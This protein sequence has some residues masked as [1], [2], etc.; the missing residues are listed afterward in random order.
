MNDLSLHNSRIEWWHHVG[1]LNSGSKSFSYQLTFFRKKLFTKQAFVVHMS[2]S[3]LNQGLYFFS[4]KKTRHACIACIDGPS[5]CMKGC[6]MSPKR[7][8]AVCDDFSF[9]LSLSEGR[10]VYHKKPNYYS[11][12]DVE[13]SGE[14][15]ID[16]DL[17]KVDGVSWI[18]H[19]WPL[20]LP[21]PKIIGWDWFALSLANGTRVMLYRLCLK[22]GRQHFMS[23]GSVIT[24]SKVKYLLDEEFSI[25]PVNKTGLYPDLWDVSIPSFN[26]ELLVKTEMA[27]QEFRSDVLKTN[28]FEG[29][30]SVTGSVSGTGYIELVGYDKPFKRS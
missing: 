23:S 2:I 11:I 21:A 26:I 27:S 4:E 29:L 7:L 24:T 13:T 5:I 17:F 25:K 30:V 14:V 28:Y 1:R 12:V 8:V 22:D 10:T 20:K 6:F 3:D 19:E 16:G 15:S 9:D 18:D